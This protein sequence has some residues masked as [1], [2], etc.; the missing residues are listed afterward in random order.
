MQ[1]FLGNGL[2]KRRPRGVG[3]GT[4]IIYFETGLPPMRDL[5]GN[6]WKPNCWFWRGDPARSAFG[7]VLVLPPEH[8][9]VGL[10][11]LLS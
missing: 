8:I 5:M 6:S 3:V 10:G 4:E 7:Y 9:S 11:L 1:G 2:Q